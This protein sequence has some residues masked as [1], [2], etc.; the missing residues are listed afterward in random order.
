MALLGDPCAGCELRPADVRTCD[1]HVDAGTG[2][3]ALG[4]GC[5]GGTHGA[6]SMRSERAT[7]AASGLVT[8]LLALVP[9]TLAAGRHALVLAVLVPTVSAGVVVAWLGGS[10]LRRVDAEADARVARAVRLLPIAAGGLLVT[11]GLTV[12]RFVLA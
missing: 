10:A 7:L 4:D 5:C 9:L 8:V 1:A 12:A 6:T 11:F 3:A 2:G